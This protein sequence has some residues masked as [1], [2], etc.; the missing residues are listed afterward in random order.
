MKHSGIVETHI[1][2]KTGWHCFYGQEIV[3]V[4]GD[5]GCS[6]CIS[7]GGDSGTG[8]PVLCV[9][10]RSDGDGSALE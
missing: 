5:H 6:Y 1:W 7:P 9:A 10:T 8:F 2:V 4:V 3:M